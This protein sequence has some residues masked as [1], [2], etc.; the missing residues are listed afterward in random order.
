MCSIWYMMDIDFNLV[1]SYI[2][3]YWYKFMEGL[4]RLIEHI[5]KFITDVCTS[6]YFAPHMLF[7][8]IC[9]GF[10][11][12]FLNTKSE[13]WCIKNTGRFLMLIASTS[14]IIYFGII[15]IVLE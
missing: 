5:C 12:V 11:S 9:I 10:V 3:V 14:G 13:K 15:I 1:W 6:L 2:K 4:T 7:L 8:S